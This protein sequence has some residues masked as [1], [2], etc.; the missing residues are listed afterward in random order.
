MSKLSIDHAIIVTQ[1]MFSYIIIYKQFKY[2]GK[3]TNKDFKM[4]KIKK[5]DHINTN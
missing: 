2:L 3:K 1:Y 5:T 4:R